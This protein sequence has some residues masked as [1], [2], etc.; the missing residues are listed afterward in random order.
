MVTV[1]GFLS[2]LMQCAPTSQRTCNLFRGLLANDTVC[3]S[4]SKQF[5]ANYF[6]RVFWTC[7]QFRHM[8]LPAASTCTWGVLYLYTVRVN[9]PWFDRGYIGTCTYLQSI[10]DTIDVSQH[11]YVPSAILQSLWV[12]FRF[13][14]RP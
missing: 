9:V 6:G 1:Y 13:P 4:R 14:T 3:M 10:I 7:I 12:G 11:E 8:Y 5:G 2:R